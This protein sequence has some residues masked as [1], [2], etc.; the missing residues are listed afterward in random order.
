VLIWIRDP[1]ICFPA[2]VDAAD[3]AAVRF[4]HLSPSGALKVQ[5]TI[6]DKRVEQGSAAKTGQVFGTIR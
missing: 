6:G 3:Q 1:L 5:Y 4:V 2:A